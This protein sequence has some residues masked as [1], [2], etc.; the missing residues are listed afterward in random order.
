MATTKK[1]YKPVWPVGVFGEREGSW[2][3]IGP[4]PTELT[5]AQF[6]A[7][8]TEAAKLGVEI[9]ETDPPADTPQDLSASGGT[10]TAP[11]V[12]GQ[13]TAKEGGK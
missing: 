11:N 4:E 9:V 3:T 10:T 13:N 6:E 8:S 1:Y 2:P 5:K 7:A 12:D